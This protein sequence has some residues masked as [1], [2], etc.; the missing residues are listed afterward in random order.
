MTD[1][2]E[3]IAAARSGRILRLKSLLSR[4]ADI[5]ARDE[6]GRTP[7]HLALASGMDFVARLLIEK[8]ADVRTQ[9]PAGVTPL[10]LAV[11]N[12]YEDIAKLLVDRGADPGAV[13]AEGRSPVSLAEEYGMTL[14]ADATSVQRG[15]ISVRPGRPQG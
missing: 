10:H 7:L 8:G 13:D 11:L 5:N 12:R 3:L 9:D 14:P 15:G 6:G 1:E 2:Y 4:G